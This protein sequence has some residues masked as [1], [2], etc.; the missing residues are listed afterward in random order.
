[1]RISYSRTGYIL[2]YLL[3][4][5]SVRAQVT[6]T[7][8]FDGDWAPCKRIEA[9]YFR[10]ITYD[11]NGKPV[12]KVNDYYA[13]GALQ[14]TGNLISVRPDVID[15]EAVWFYPDSTLQQRAVY[16]NG[17]P[18]GLFESFYENA[19]ASERKFYIH[20]IQ[21]SEALI[22]WPDGS[23]KS[24]RNFRNGVLHGTAIEYFSN[25]D[26]A[27]HG[28][29]FNGVQDTVI[30]FYHENNN[31]SMLY[32]LNADSILNIKTFSDKGILQSS[33]NL[34]HNIP[35]GAQLHYHSNGT[36]SDSS[37][38]IN[39]KL[40]GVAIS[41]Y[42][43]GTVKSKMNYENNLLH[44]EW[45]E[46]SSTGNLIVQKYYSNGKLHG[47]YESWYGSGILKEKGNYNNGERNGK[48]S[49][50]SDTD[51]KLIRASDYIDDVIISDSLFYNNGSIKEVV[52]ASGPGKPPSFYAYDETGRLI[53]IYPPDSL[54]LKLTKDIVTG[55]YGFKNKRNQWK[56]LPVYEEVRGGQ[57][58]FIVRMDGKYGVL[59]Y[60]GTIAVFCRYDTL[61]DVTSSDPQHV[62]DYPVIY[63]PLDKTYL[64]RQENKYGVISSA[65]TTIIQFGYD[66]IET[67][68][69][70]NFIIIKD[71]LRGFANAEGKIIVKPLYKTLRYIKSAACLSY[72]DESGK[73]GLISLS[74]KVMVPSGYDRIYFGNPQQRY[75]WVQN[76]NYFG[77]FDSSGSLKLPVDYKF[78][79]ENDLN[80]NQLGY[81]VEHFVLA[82]RENRYGVVMNDG[83]IILPFSFSRIN[84]LYDHSESGRIIYFEIQ[85]NDKWGVAD[86]SGNIIVEPVYDRVHSSWFPRIANNRLLP[87]FI[88]C[89]NGKTGMIDERNNILI[90][91]KYEGIGT[92]GKN[93]YYIY[94]EDKLSWLNRETKRMSRDS[95][96]E[97]GNNLLRFTVYGCQPQ[98]EYNDGLAFKSGK[99][100]LKPGYDIHFEDSIAI[101]TDSSGKNIVIDQQGNIHAHKL[102]Y[103]YTVNAPGEFIVVQSAGGRLGINDV[104]GKIILDTLYY[105]FAFPDSGH[106]WAV[107]DSVSVSDD[108]Y[109]EGYGVEGRWKLFNSD[110]L[111]LSDSVFSNVADFNGSVSI[112][113]LENGKQV[114]IN[115]N[116]KAVTDIPYELINH[117]SDRTF[118]VNFGDSVFVYD[119]ITGKDFII[120]CNELGS[121]L[122]KYAIAKRDDLYG[123]ADIEGRIVYGFELTDI[124]GS[125]WMLIDSL[126]LR[127]SDLIN[128][129][130]LKSD[131]V[132]NADS[133]SVKTISNRIAGLVLSQFMKGENE[134]SSGLSEY[135]YKGEYYL[136]DPIQVSYFGTTEGYTDRVELISCTPSAFTVR[137]E[138]ETWYSPSRGAG[139]SHISETYQTYRIS[140]T[141]SW[142]LTLDSVLTMDSSCIAF[143]DSAIYGPAELLGNDDPQEFQF[144]IEKRGLR[145]FYGN[146]E[147]EIKSRFISWLVLVPYLRMDI[148]TEIK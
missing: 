34:K 120:H 55:L 49:Y 29:Y 82:D 138:T 23:L 129:T 98:Q 140:G 116:G 39:G 35:E 79:Y 142:I 78:K 73:E 122:D 117:G 90:P 143:L 133:L 59:N 17:E 37:Y 148:M 24:K 68:G 40:E 93:L 50:Y 109:I 97:P 92:A 144:A 130:L 70:G 22:F 61:I 72:S 108:E 124:A 127:E 12:G 15:G 57:F 113:V 4:S 77:V 1:M 44:G 6:V 18:D 66:A 88:V 43:D 7:E 146:S 75:F 51:E 60:D 95:I 71:G 83:T 21:E 139:T 74:G 64:A 91:F 19:N 110:G 137:I 41:R 87:Y 27:M 10:V 103:V 56:T 5:I 20:G 128:I 32:E 94:N 36:I 141:E 80:Q 3:L 2:I 96:G 81:P 65:G 54:Q 76:A 69:D 125:N 46:Y 114:L 67:A 107:L 13:G 45:I 106:I 101:A 89:K 63:W 131:T 33:V 9:K 62:Y 123:I 145:F 135:A 31:I 26:T 99:I 126:K 115:Q 121:F 11:E 102:D 58:P 85:R 25:G 134:I 48:F 104:S 111:S 30:V 119:E 86:S 53:S 16:K 118:R 147:E 42:P 105:G 14:W 136:P 52:H 38:F 47:D 100:I 112:A 28:R 84:R 132:C 8:F